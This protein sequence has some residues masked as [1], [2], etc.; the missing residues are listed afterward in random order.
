M[1]LGDNMKTFK[2]IQP[3]IIN[4]L[5]VVAIFIS[6]L[7]ISKTSP[8]GSNVLGNPDA[9]ARFKPLLFN[10]I[11][12]LKNGTLDIYSFN[13]GLGHPFLFNYIY[14]LISP[15]NLIALLFKKADHM[16]LSVIIAD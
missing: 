3:Y 2:K 14:Y 11:T 1:K 10:F 6:I 16:F 8:F 12:N 13:N 9:I 7:I 15:L 5:I 4:T